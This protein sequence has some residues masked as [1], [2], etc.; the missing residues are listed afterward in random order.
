MNEYLVTSDRLA[1][2]RG[3][4]LDSESCGYGRVQI[5]RLV[6]G[7]H[8]TKIGAGRETSIAHR[9]QSPAGADLSPLPQEEE[10]DED[11]DNSE[12][13]EPE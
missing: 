1:H 9:R 2:A 3:V 5:E 6:A 7:G 8:L 4:I 10:L 11:S 13:K 12:T